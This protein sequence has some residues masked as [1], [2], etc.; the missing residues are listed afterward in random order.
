MAPGVIFFTRIIAGVVEAGWTTFIRR[1]H[2]INAGYSYPQGVIDR[3]HPVGVSPCQ[4]VVNCNQMA[5]RTGKGVQVKGK[6]SHQGF[7]LTSFHLSDSALMEDN[8]PHQLH[9]KVALA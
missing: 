2:G 3:S 9:I 4:V 6:G 1:L 7:T 5:T 8:T